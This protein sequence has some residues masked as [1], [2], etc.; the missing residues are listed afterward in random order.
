M[1]IYR[2]QAG[3]QSPKKDDRR[4]GTS[5]GSWYD[6]PAKDAG[7]FMRAGTGRGTTSGGFWRGDGPDEVLI[8]FP[9]RKRQRCRSLVRILE[10]VKVPIKTCPTCARSSRRR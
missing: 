5:A 1:L 7:A 6:D 4:M 8:A 3:A 10:P 2:R 9:P